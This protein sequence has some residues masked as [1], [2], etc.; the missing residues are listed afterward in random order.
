MEN[1]ALKLQVETENVPE[2]TR[3]LIEHEI[4]NEIIGHTEDDDI[5]IQIE[6]GFEQQ[7]GVDELLEISE[8]FEDD[9]DEDEEED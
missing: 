3:V 9:L 1:V 2:F 5:I 4:D 7:D 8:I 6:Y